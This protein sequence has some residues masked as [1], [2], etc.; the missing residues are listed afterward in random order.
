MFIKKKYNENIYIFIKSSNNDLFKRILNFRNIAIIYDGI[1][2]NEIVKIINYFKKYHI[3]IFIIDNFKLAI[4]FKLNGVVISHNNKRNNIFNRSLSNKKFE[5]IGKVHNQMEYYFKINQ[6][7]KNI[8]LSPLFKTKK[9]NEF[10][11]LNIIRFNLITTSWKVQ[12]LGLG[13]INNTNYKKLKMTKVKGF[14]FVSFI[15][16]PKTKKPVNL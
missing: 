11:V 13:G 15:G 4:K 16:D 9:Y 7:C 2:H 5:I 3:K 14:G 12:L 8:F 6:N 10:K 1:D